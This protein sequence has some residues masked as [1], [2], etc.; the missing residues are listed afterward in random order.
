MRRPARWRLLR[1]IASNGGPLYVCLCC[2]HV[3]PT[4]V[5]KCPE[6]SEKQWSCSRWIATMLEMRP[7]TPKEDC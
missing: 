7:V 5:V 1:R 6:E 2:G 3:S 4:P